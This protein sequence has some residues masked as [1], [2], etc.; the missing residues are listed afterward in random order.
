MKST[1]KNERT[2]SKTINKHINL[3]NKIISEK[4][5][6][7]GMKLIIKIKKKTLQQKEK[8]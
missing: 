8:R 4:A 7:K 3:P 1:I 6:R 5:E 2:N